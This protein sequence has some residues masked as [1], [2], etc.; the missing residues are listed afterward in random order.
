MRGFLKD[1]LQARTLRESLVEDPRERYY[2][3]RVDPMIEDVLRRVAGRVHRFGMSQDIPPSRWEPGFRLPP[4]DVVS[5][6]G[7]S[8]PGG[9]RR[10]IP[11][12]LED[13]IL[14][15]LISLIENSVA[16]SERLVREE[17]DAEADIYDDTISSLER[18]ASVLSGLSESERQPV[19]FP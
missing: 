7:F 13:E 18:W 14:L 6:G 2:V 5:G 12:V 10:H 9:M 19:M 11:A 3:E 8:I 17:T 1:L 4:S 16:D 15:K